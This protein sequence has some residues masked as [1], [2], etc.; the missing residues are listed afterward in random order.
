MPLP[1]WWMSEETRN[2]LL[3]QYR[4]PAASAV[5][6]VLATLSVVGALDT[7]PSHTVYVR[8]LQFG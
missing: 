6:T 5:S 1:A 8:L 3:K 2:R 4:I 7:I